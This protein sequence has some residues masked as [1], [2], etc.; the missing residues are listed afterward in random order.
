MDATGDPSPSSIP[1]GAAAASFCSEGS[2]IFL[3]GGMSDNCRFTNKLYVLNMST[4]TW[5]VHKTKINA[6]LG[7]DVPAPRIGAS[8]VVAG[9]Q[10]YS[11]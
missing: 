4:W 1:P 10:I 5:K 3:F 9:N 8:M 11:V 7:R 6:E 2:R